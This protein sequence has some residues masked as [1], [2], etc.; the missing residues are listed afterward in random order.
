M[1]AGSAE[2]ECGWEG[3]GGSVSGQLQCAMLAYGVPSLLRL[4]K[5]QA[6]HAL[7]STHTHARTDARTLGH[8]HLYAHSHARNHA[9]AHTHT[10]THA[11]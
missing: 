7:T 8:S 6:S 4:A 3:L 11:P 1:S 10:N 9:H 5:N 2:A